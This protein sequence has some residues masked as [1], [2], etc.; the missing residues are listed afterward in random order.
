MLKIKLEKE[1]PLHS[2][3]LTSEEA[4]QEQFLKIVENLWKEEAPFWE[5]ISLQAMEVIDGA[6]RE[7]DYTIVSD[8]GRGC[9]H[10]LS[11]E[12]QAA[13]ILIYGQ[14][15]YR[16]PRRV[17]L[18]MFSTE[19]LTWL[20]RLEMDIDVLL[21]AEIGDDWVLDEQAKAISLLAVR[22]QFEVEGQL[23]GP[24]IKDWESEL[25]AMVREVD[26]MYRGMD[27]AQEARGYN[28][29]YSFREKERVIS[30]MRQELEM[31]DFLQLFGMEAPEYNHFH[32]INTCR[33]L[34]TAGE[35]GQKMLILLDD[36]G[37]HQYN[38]SGENFGRILVNQILGRYREQKEAFALL[39][40]CDMETFRTTRYPELTE[41]GV[42]LDFEQAEVTVYHKHKA[43]REFHRLYVEAFG[44]WV[45]EDD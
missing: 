28:R 19:T 13:L 39:M 15:R 6:Q 36:R 27:P 45:E 14:N 20:N 11:Y 44:E 2:I 37:V 42:M 38:I 43:I 32:I 25:Q 16:V 3:Y 8:R 34:C 30:G 29:Y 26:Y 31:A 18:A 10:S 4:V 12:C 17:R 21:P 40:N 22:E 7:G 23:I 1:Y 35:A 41:L 9:M 33:T 24:G 5:P